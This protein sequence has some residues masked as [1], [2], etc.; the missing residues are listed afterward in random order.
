MSVDLLGEVH[1]ADKNSDRVVGAWIRAGKPRDGAKFDAVGL[2]RAR[3][4]AAWTAYEL[5]SAI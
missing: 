1:A 2:A 4:A 5:D 3:C